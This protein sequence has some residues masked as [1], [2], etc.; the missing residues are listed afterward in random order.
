MASATSYDE[1]VYTDNSFAETHPLHLAA[2]ATLFGVPIPDLSQCRVLELGC[3]MGGNLIPMAFSLPGGNYLGIDLSARQIAEGQKTIADLGI[4]NVTLRHQS[5]LDFGPEDGTFDFILCHGVY[6]WVPDMVREKILSILANQLTPSGV[7]YV[8]YNTYPGWHMRGMVRDIM[9]YHAQQFPA[10]SEKVEQ[11]RAFLGFLSQA[12]SRKKS[13]YVQLLQDEIELLSDVPDTYLFHEHLEDN[14]DPV[15]FHEFA[16]RASAHGLQYVGETTLHHNWASGFS[17]DVVEVLERI[18]HDVVHAQQYLDFLRNTGF[19]RSILCRADLPVRHDLEVSAFSQLEVATAACPIEAEPDIRS[20]EV[21][22]FESR[23]GKLATDEPIIKAAILLLAEAWPR[24]MPFAKLT[25]AALQRLDGSSALATTNDR[26]LLEQMLLNAT[27]SAEIFEWR[28]ANPEF[29]TSVSGH[30][31]ACP[32]AR[33]KLLHGNRL[34]NRLHRT[35]EISDPVTRH[36]LL[37]CDG[38]HSQED[39]TASLITLARDGKLVMR[40]DQG[41]PVTDPETLRSMLH[42]SVLKILNGLGSAGVLMA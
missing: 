11:A 1:L 26:E 18:S 23:G 30:P 15:Y 38:Q 22:H 10:A 29:Q 35:V 34:T 12:V 41:Q 21:V 3:G 27:R 31:V 19:R 33:Y 17:P 20:R 2:V 16:A 4:H 36:I 5:I 6:S 9:R 39:L 42:T 14:N 24:S 7:A 25:L 32:L 13:A 37:H 28:A 40:D 8:S